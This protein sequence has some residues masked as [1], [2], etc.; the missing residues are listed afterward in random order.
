MHVLNAAKK[1][2]FLDLETRKNEKALKD[3]WWNYCSKHQKPYLVAY[4]K[5]TFY[6]V[7]IDLLSVSVYTKFTDEELML[8]AN[9]ENVCFK[10]SQND[11]LGHVVIILN[12]VYPEK[13]PELVKAVL[14]F[15]GK[16]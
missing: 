2:G 15:V 9:L 11:L 10:P 12:S 3:A 5:K 13:L 1:N 4:K 14:E 6:R 16:K 7:D 8:I